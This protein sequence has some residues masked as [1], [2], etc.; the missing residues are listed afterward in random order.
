[1]ISRFNGNTKEIQLWKKIL[2]MIPVHIFVV[3]V[4]FEVLS[5]E[6]SLYVI[7]NCSIYIYLS[8]CF[9]FT[10]LLKKEVSGPEAKETQDQKLCDSE[11]AMFCFLGF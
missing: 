7:H 6:Y 11:S 2:Q 1:M 5:K 8:L 4:I 9:F 10:K 3:V